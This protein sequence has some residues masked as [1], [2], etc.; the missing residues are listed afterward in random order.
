MIVRII[1]WLMFSTYDYSVMVDWCLQHMIIQSWFV[2]VRNIWLFSYGW[3]CLCWESIVCIS[4]INYRG[5]FSSFIM[6]CRVFEF[7]VY[8]IWLWLWRSC[9]IAF[10][11]TALH[12]IWS[13]VANLWFTTTKWRFRER[14]GIFMRVINNSHEN[15]YF[16]EG[17]KKTL[18]KIYF[19]EGILWTLTIMFIFV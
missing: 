1:V 6:V 5:L 7:G 13:Y 14:S 12:G 16:R 17:Q 8:V 19:C 3:C 2:D 4:G 10:H 9:C 11:G 15:V 18:T